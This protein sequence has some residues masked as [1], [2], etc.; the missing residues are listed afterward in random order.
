MIRKNKK[1]VVCQRQRVSLS[2]SGAVILPPLE[3]HD[4]SCSVKLGCD[5]SWDGHAFAESTI[6]HYA[7][8]N[9]AIVQFVF[10]VSRD[11]KMSG[12]IK[13]FLF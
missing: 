6:A 2:G 9:E 11:K 3:G 4:I 7:T 5:C 13:D 1:M 10:L 12:E 8:W